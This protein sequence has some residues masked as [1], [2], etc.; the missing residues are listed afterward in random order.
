MVN[1]TFR[2][3]K[4][5]VATV[6][7]GSVSEASRRLFIAQPS[8][9]SAIKSLE[10]NFGI[11]F[12]IRQHAQG[13]TLTPAGIRFHHKA[14][15]LLR[16]LREFEQNALADNDIVSGQIDIGCFETLGPIYLPRLIAEFKQRYPGVTL[17]IRD[18]DQSDMLSSIRCGQLDLAIVYNQEIEHSEFGSSLL[19]NDLHPYIM[20]SANH[21]LAKRDSVSLKEISKEPMILL[22]LLPSKNYFLDVFRLYDLAPRIAFRSPSLEMVRGLVGQG[23][24]FSIMVSQPETS[25]TYDGNRIVSLKIEE[26]VD[27]ISLSAVWLKSNQL[28]RPARLFVDFCHQMLNK[29]CIDN[30]DKI[31]SIE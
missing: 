9:S 8:I 18:G 13:I 15:E 1:Y 22:D 12:F 28:T 25:V 19:L 27:S 31:L 6:E 30:S 26:P 11:Q 5:F 10:D 21:P 2:Q 16:V 7:C 4:Y 20:L 3:L 24:G 14:Q 29:D 23:L 17:N